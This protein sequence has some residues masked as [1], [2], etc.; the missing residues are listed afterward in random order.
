MIKKLQHI[1]ILNFATQRNFTFKNLTLS[2]QVFGCPLGTAPIVL[3]NHALTGNSE[4]TGKNGWWNALIGE[5]KTINTQ[6]FTI[7]AFNIPGNGFDGQL[8]N[9][10]KKIT[11]K[12]I[13]KLFLMGLSHLNITELH[14]IIGGSLGGAIAWEMAVLQPNITQHLIPIACDWKA[15]DWIIA[16]SLVQDQI[17][18]NSKNPVH[19]ARLHA[20][21]CYRTPASF[22]ARF[23]RSIN[24]N[25][26]V[27]NTESWLLHHG[28]KLQKRFQLAA[29]K[30]MNHLLKTI[31]ASSGSNVPFKVLQTINANICMVGINTDLF[32]T[33]TENIET[34]KK[35]SKHHNNVS[36]HEIDS[37]HGH[38]AFLIEYKQLEQII[39][40]IFTKNN[41]KINL[42]NQL[43]APL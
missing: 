15:S 8:I 11:T 3:V 17:L 42:K 34:Q 1:P 16:N 26:L 40:P 23:N 38:D 18:N 29:Y 25:L 13:A 7:L 30:L 36:Y 28:E 33:A 24:N 37:I 43:V 31:D 32:F 10:Y 21:L 20:M 22:K 19:D 4:V 12:E 5:E 35:L 41:I 39:A 2:Y 14:S 9:N 6:H 27:F